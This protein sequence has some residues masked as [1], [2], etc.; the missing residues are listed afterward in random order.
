MKVIEV[1]RLLQISQRDAEERERM[2]LL[3]ISYCLR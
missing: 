1:E 3:C 2:S